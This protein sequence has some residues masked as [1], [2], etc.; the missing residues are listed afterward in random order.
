[1]FDSETI[2][3]LLEYRLRMSGNSE[4]IYDFDENKRYTYNDLDRRSDALAHFLFDE[5]HMQKGDRMG[6]CAVNNIAFYDAYF[7]SYKTGVVITTY[8][9]LLKEKELHALIENEEPSV[10][11]YTAE[12]EATIEGLKNAGFKQVFIC[13]DKKAEKGGYDYSE[14]IE[15]TYTA[16][17]TPPDISFEDIQMLIHT[18]GTTGKPKAAMMSYRAIFYNT[19]ADQSVFELTSKDCA[20][21]TLPLFHTAGW[22]VLNTPLLYA[23]GRII[24]IHGFNPDKVLKIIRE[25]RP[26]VCMSV[27]TI[28]RSLAGHPDFEKVDFS[29]F[30]FMIT[31]AAPTGRELLNV[32]WN[33]GVKILNAYGMTEIGPNNICPPISMMSIEAVREKW[34]SCGKPAPFNQIRFLD[35]NGNEVKRGE[36][37]ELVFTGK[38][39]FSGYWNNPEASDKM[40]HDGWVRSGD[41]GYLDEDGFCYIS[42]RKKNMFISGGENIFP[43]EIEDV[44]M[45]IPG[46]WEACVVG[47]P[48]H[49]WGEV[50]R[51]LIVADPSENV[52]REKI[53]SKVR[54]EMSSIKIPKYVS[55]VD[56]VPKN[57]VGKRDLNLLKE[58]FGKAED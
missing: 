40:L 46:I 5:L 18:G 14:L 12:F 22:N 57:A 35:E 53:I 28:Y 31:G 54:E 47:V 50:G 29:C 34:N 38:L 23:G 55:F 30:R 19:L 20:I 9:C 15:K 43:Q 17:L 58:L 25:E 33:R 45:T 8:N 51:V 42:G 6:F 32:Y 3:N 21:L 48:D 56:E 41:M 13:L 26:T 11:F 24:L 27:E 16:K 39:L 52:T 49:K 37:G 1:M 2:S 36:R 10:I 44:I 7:A 4:A